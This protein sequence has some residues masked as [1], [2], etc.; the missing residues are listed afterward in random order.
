VAVYIG[1]INFFFVKFSY[2]RCA[3]M[4][5]IKLVHHMTAVHTCTISN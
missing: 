2:D 3:Y 1:A 5:N 4:Y